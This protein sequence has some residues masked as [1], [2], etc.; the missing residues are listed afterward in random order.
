MKPQDYGQQWLPWAL[1]WAKHIDKIAFSSCIVLGKEPTNQG[2]QSKTSKWQGHLPWAKFA[3]KRRVYW[4]HSLYH[5]P[6]LVSVFF[7][8]IFPEDLP[9]GNILGWC[10]RITQYVCLESGNGLSWN[11]SETQEDQKGLAES[12]WEGKRQVREGT[13]AK[14]QAWWA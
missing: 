12:N 7:Y 14:M 13:G 10:P 2:V 8:I 6:N 9:L 3:Q 5:L 11:W 1:Q 4:R